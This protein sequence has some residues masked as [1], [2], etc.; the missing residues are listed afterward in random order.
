M[1]PTA[2]MP[3][4]QATGTERLTHVHWPSASRDDVGRLLLRIRAEYTEMP[5]LRLTLRQA[6]RLFGLPADVTAVVLGELHEAAVLTRSADGAY[7]L[8][9]QSS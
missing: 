4:P 1:S 7:S 3:E 6:A 9:R 8:R 2:L 5:G